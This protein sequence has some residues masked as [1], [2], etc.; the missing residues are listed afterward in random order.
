M[1]H[2]LGVAALQVGH[3]VSLVVLMQGDDQPLHPGTSAVEVLD[4]CGVLHA[5]IPSSTHSV[6]IA[7]LT[8]TMAAAFA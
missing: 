4:L 2:M 5:T 3:P 6:M 8:N 7:H 1:S